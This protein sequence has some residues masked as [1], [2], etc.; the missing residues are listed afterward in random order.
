VRAR[1]SHG[2]ARKRTYEAGGEA[3]GQRRGLETAVAKRGNGTRNVWR[4]VP[5]LVTGRVIAG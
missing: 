4:V 1:S 2:E 5:V 3:K